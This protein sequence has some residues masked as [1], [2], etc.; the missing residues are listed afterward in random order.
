[1]HLKIFIAGQFSEN[2]FN[3]FGKQNILLKSTVEK[4]DVYVFYK[5]VNE[6][7]LSIIQQIEELDKIVCQAETEI[8][9]SKTEIVSLEALLKKLEEKKATLETNADEFK[10]I[11]SHI[12]QSTTQIAMHEDT[13]EEM[14]RKAN[15]TKAMVAEL[16]K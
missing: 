12:K 13:I 1:M 6:L 7:G 8:L 4:G 14:T 3:D 10:K 15:D 11:E 5:P 16:L 2:D 9:T